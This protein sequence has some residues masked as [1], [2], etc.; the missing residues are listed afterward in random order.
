MAASGGRTFI[1]GFSL[2]LHLFF[3]RL[4]LYLGKKLLSR[5]KGD[6][7]A[8]F[9]HEKS[10]LRIPAFIVTGSDSGSFMLWDYLNFFIYTEKNIHLTLWLSVK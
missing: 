5:K 6:L 2:K 3:C 7:N 8:G 4:A 9:D 1:R 10:A